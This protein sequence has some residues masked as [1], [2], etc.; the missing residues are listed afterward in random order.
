MNEISNP[1]R[2]QKQL[3]WV[4]GACERLE[5]L[6]LIKAG[7]SRI[8]SKYTDLYLQIDEERKEI[9]SSLEELVKVSAGAILTDLS[10]IVKHNMKSGI[11]K[12]S[13]EVMGCKDIEEQNE[14]IAKIIMAICAYYDCRDQLLA[15][16]FNNMM[17]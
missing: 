2:E 14:A 8:D 10:E 15:F 16:A 4:I 5:G 1:T 13:W 11:C 12:S 6:G 3:L 9:F 7:I 17:K